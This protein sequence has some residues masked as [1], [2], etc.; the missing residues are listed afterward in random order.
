[1]AL[2]SSLIDLSSTLWLLNAE[3]YNVK[4]RDEGDG[5]WRRDGAVIA[6]A[7]AYTEY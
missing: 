4:R 2:S 3:T 1:M 5:E 6:R 7:R